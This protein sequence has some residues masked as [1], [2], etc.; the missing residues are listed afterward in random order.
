[1]KYPTHLGGFQHVHFTMEE[2][3]APAVVLKI[4]RLSNYMNG[5]FENRP[6]ASCRL[7]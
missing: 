1:M 6:L 5:S 4:K 2:I 7:E 3:T